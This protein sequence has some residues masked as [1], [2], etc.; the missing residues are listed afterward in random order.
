[1]VFSAF[2]SLFLCVPWPRQ[3]AD[4]NTPTVAPGKPILGGFA[5]IGMPMKGHRA[6]KGFSTAIARMAATKFIPAAAIKTP[7]QPAE[8]AA[9]RLASGT[10]SEA[11]PF[12]T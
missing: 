3:F 9:M 12:A 7:F 11:T 10:T 2:R 4:G 5:V 8:D 1:M 6:R